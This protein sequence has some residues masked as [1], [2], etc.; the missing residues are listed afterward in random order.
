MRKYILVLFVLATYQLSG[1]FDCTSY[2]P[3]KQGTK[4]WYHNYN[5][6][7]ELLSSTENKVLLV[8]TV[9]DGTT[10]AEISSII[11]DESGKEDFTGEYVVNC[12]DGILE[13]EVMSSLTP[14]M[15]QSF[16]GMEM[17]LVGDL[18]SMPEKLE[19]GMKLADASTKI[20]AATD[21]VNIISMDFHVNERKVEKLEKIITP[22][23]EYD[24]YKISAQ[25]KVDMMIEKHFTTI[26]YYSEK[27]GLVR[28][29]TLDH[30]GKLISYAE[31][32]KLES[33]K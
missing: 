16:Q 21:G 11:R 22:A 19:V 29:E 32:I 31:L 4:M 1:Q 30:S 12:K 8:R 20:N 24:C 14:A 5:A 23:G 27:V 9:P 7:G 6:E 13:L 15:L 26:E 28:T 25:T 33:P 18:L 2:Y 10:E 17:T 3:F